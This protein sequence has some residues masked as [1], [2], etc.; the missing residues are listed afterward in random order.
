MSDEIVFAASDLHFHN[1]N[2]NASSGKT[3]DMKTFDLKLSADSITYSSYYGD[4]RSACISRVPLTFEN[5]GIIE[6]D[7]SIL[8]GT[9]Q[10]NVL[11]K[12]PSYAFFDNLTIEGDLT[13]S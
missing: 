10:G 9:I 1:C 7:K 5:T 13:I 3:L 6:V 12:S 2:I 11:L 8:G 4:M